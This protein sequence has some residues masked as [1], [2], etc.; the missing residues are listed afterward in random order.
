MVCCDARFL[1]EDITL[2]RRYVGQMRPPLPFDG[3]RDPWDILGCGDDRKCATAAEF[4]EAH[5][6]VGL[7]LLRGR[8]ILL[9]RL[10]AATPDGFS[11]G[12]AD[13]LHDAV[14]FND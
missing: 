9:D 13:L 11:N 14:P 6:W 4:A 1:G 7:Q 8:S 2:L 5:K 12:W 10:R 3:T